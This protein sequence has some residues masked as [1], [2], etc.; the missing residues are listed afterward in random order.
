MSEVDPGLGSTNVNVTLAP[1]DNPFSGKRF[2]CC[3]CG[4]GLEIRLSRRLKPYTQCLTCGIQTFFRGKKGIQRLSEIVKSELLMAGRGSKTE[5]AVLLYTRIQQLRA[6]KEE[7]EAQQGFILRDADL[8]GVIRVVDNEL[9]RVQG[10]LEQ[11]AGPSREE[12]GK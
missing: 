8:D 1:R 10:E 5:S 2:P 4:V 12:N 11:M 3:L 6:Q 9:A 7:L